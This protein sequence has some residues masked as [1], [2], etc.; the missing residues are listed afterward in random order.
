MSEKF[1][2][3]E[4]FVEVSKKAKNTLKSVL[5]EILQEEDFL[6]AP[7]SSEV[8]P[9]KPS[10]IPQDYTGRDLMDI[11]SGGGSRYKEIK[12][13]FNPKS[14]I[15]IDRDPKVIKAGK[16]RNLD[17]SPADFI[18]DNI[19]GDLGVMFGTSTSPEVVRKLGQYFNLLV[20]S[21]YAENKIREAEIID[22]YK[23]QLGKDNFDKIQSFKRTL[24][25]PASGQS[26]YFFYRPKHAE[27]AMSF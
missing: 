5:A 25:S 15:G 19:K 12:I 16:R 3:W 17:I 18:S 2:A 22:Q 24:I 21:E 13:L 14:Y 23:T 6:L 1:R 27:D 9:L 7:I 4:Q 8:L 11:G 20:F 10:D 26:L